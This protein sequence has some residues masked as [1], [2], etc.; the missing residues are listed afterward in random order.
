[1]PFLCLLKK[2]RTNAVYYVYLPAVFL[3][4]SSYR[5]EFLSDNVFLQSE[6]LSLR[7]DLLVNSAL[8]FLSVLKCFHL[9]F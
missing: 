4:I 7:A 6:E 3:F 9:H 8:I 2:S 1:M 5:L